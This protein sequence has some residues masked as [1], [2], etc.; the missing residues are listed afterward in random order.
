VFAQL[1]SAPAGLKPGNERFPGLLVT[2]AHGDSQVAKVSDYESDGDDLENR[3]HQFSCR[4]G[5]KES[6]R[7]TYSY[8]NRGICELDQCY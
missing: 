1:A 2:A 5:A 6:G 4:D 3:K 7:P 8:K